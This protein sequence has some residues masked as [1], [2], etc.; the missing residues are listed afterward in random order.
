MKS[1]VVVT[2]YK[3]PLH[4]GIVQHAY[5][6]YEEKQAIKI[7]KQLLAQHAEDARKGNL[8]ISACRVIDDADPRKTQDL[9]TY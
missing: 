6:P 5:G 3:N 4:G 8:S 9:R 1:H 7:R 2:Y